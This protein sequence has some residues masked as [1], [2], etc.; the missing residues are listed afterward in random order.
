MPRDTPIDVFFTM[1]EEEFLLGRRSASAIL[2]AD[3]EVRWGRKV[4][5]A[6][7]V[8]LGPG[9]RRQ[10]TD[11]VSNSLPGSIPP[12]AFDQLR[13]SIP[14]L[15]ERIVAHLHDDGFDGPSS[16]L[17]ERINTT[18]IETYF[19]PMI[20]ALEDYACAADIFDNILDAIREATFA[21]ERHRGLAAL[22]L[23]ASTAFLGDLERAGN[24]TVQFA[25]SEF[26]VDLL[27]EWDP[28]VAREHEDVPVELG[29]QR[30]IRGDIRGRRHTLEPAGTMFG[31]LPSLECDYVADV[32][33]SVSYQHLMVYQDAD[34]RWLAQDLGSTWGTTIER[35]GVAEPIVVAL[36]LA[37]QGNEEPE[38]V[39]IAPKDVLV[40]GSTRFEVQLFQRGE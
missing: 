21:S 34:G 36:P 10:L 11:Y 7:Q 32:N 19:M 18:L 15:Y 4:R 31:S 8:A 2:L 20:C 29:V 9:D 28:S 17:Y 35:P 24:L 26:G 1:L 16:A 3:R 12:E 25:S 6:R 30:I 23:H 37:Q 27:E 39:E 13:V 5:N 40:L 38:P 33:N 22:A 14:K